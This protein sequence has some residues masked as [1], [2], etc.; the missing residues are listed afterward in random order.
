MYASRYF[1]AHLR[2]IILERDGYRCQLCLRDREVLRGLGLHLEV[3]HIL[4]YIDEGK[5]THSNG[6][7]LCSQYNVAKHHAKGYLSAIQSLEEE[8]VL[9]KK[10]RLAWSPHIYMLVNDRRRTP[11]IQ[12]AIV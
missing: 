9:P 1:P 3:D 12:L 7:T 8:T 10:S 5:T 2:A 11:Y 4:S 6:R